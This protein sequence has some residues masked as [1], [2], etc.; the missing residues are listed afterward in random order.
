MQ[1]DNLRKY[2]EKASLYGM[3][4]D[5]YKYMDPE[6][7]AF[8]YQKHFHYVR[9][10]AALY[11]MGARF[12]IPFPQQKVKESRVRVLHASPDA[13]SVDVYANDRLLLADISYQEVTAYIRV[14]SGRYR[15]DIFPAGSTT[16]PIKS[17]VIRVEAG[18]TYTLA[19][20]GI[21]EELQLVAI[22]DQLSMTPG[23]AK[24]RF[25]HLSPD[26]PAVDVGVKGGETLFRDVSFQ[27]ATE[28]VTVHP[29]GQVVQVRP[30]GQETVVLE[31]PGV[32]FEPNKTY[33]V[34]ATGFLE[35]KPSLEAILLEG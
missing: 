21:A 34:V 22:H 5:Y 23:R 8:F 28:Y 20:T 1:R 15:I 3:L 9:K 26:A 4:A 35:G 16:N 18:N 10:T 31:V 14:P 33:T 6:R 17:E 7:H 11:D 13:P 30:A 2:A 27:E 24:V 19:A 29:G 32:T 12:E 25:L